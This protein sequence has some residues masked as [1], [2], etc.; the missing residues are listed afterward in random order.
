MHCL[1]LIHSCIL[2]VV[3]VQATNSLKY[4]RWCIR[5]A[6][7]CGPVKH[8][9]IWHPMTCQLRIYVT[10]TTAWVV[11]IMTIQMANMSPGQIRN[12]VWRFTIFDLITAPTLT[13]PPPLTFYFIFTYFRPLDDLFS[14]FLLY[15]HLS[16]PTWRSFGT[17]GREQIYIS[18][19]GTY[20]V[21]YGMF[22]LK[23]LCDSI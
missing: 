22:I 7:A 17:S 9:P 14:D 3:I 23:Q 19:P 1:F 8:P 5:Y 20:K 15:F 10:M 18:A 4:T 16:S 6:D 13:T 21:E 12:I 2:I 11:Q